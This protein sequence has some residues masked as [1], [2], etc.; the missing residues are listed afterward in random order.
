MKEIPLTQGKVTLVDDEDYDMVCAAGS[1]SYKEPGYAR[2]YKHGRLHRWLLRP[3]D[4]LNVDHI[5][6][7]GLDNRMC[8]LREATQ[9][10]N[11]MNSRPRVGWTS[12]YKGV[13]INRASGKWMAT[14]RID[15]E[16]KYLGI[17]ENEVDAANA[18]KQQAN[19][20]FGEFARF[21]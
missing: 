12:K 4:G 6:G 15:G 10:Q 21:E 2:S 9:S 14:I 13:S 8:N 7:N 17:F 19:K 11:L 18:Y 3:R 16:N 5:N 1:W 20:S